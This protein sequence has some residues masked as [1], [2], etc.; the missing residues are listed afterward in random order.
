MKKGNAKVYM[1]G[2]WRRERKPRFL[3]RAVAADVNRYPK[4]RKVWKVWASSAD[5]A[6]Y[7]IAAGEGEVVK[8]IGY[9]AANAR[10]LVISRVEYGRGI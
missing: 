8:D 7:K 9:K 3:C 4:L 2:C 10:R 5:S 1:M 6:R